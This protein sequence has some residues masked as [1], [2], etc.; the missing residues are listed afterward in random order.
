MNKSHRR[1]NIEV[2]HCLCIDS[3]KLTSISWVGV[4]DNT[5]Q[6]YPTVLTWSLGRTCDTDACMCTK[7]TSGNDHAELHNHKWGTSKA[8]I[9]GITAHITTLADLVIQGLYRKAYTRPYFSYRARSEPLAF[10]CAIT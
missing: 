4:Y 7:T 5:Y 6:N 10:I 3:K 9:N 8:Q 2:Q 1:F